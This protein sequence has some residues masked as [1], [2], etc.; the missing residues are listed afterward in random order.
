MPA[1]ARP[2]G[3]TYFETVPPPWRATPP[4]SS[5]FEVG[6][7]F[8]STMRVDCGQIDTAAVIRRDA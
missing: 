7:H 4:S 1:A 2:K 5:T 3:V 8:R 6:R